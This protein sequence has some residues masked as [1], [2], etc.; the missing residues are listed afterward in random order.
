METIISAKNLVKVYGEPPSETIAL[1]GVSLKIKKGEFAAIIG[2][3][4]SGK[5]TLMHILGCLDRA[6]SGEY[7]FENKNVSK[8]SENKLAQIR[9]KKIGFVF[10]FFNLLPRTSTTKNVELP[11][12]YSQVEK[13]QRQ[14]KA[15]ELLSALGLSDKLNSTPAQLSGGQQQK[16]AIARALVNNPLLIFAD[17]PTGNLDT[18]SSHE[19]MAIF[20]KLNTE[21]HTIIIITHEK[22]IAGY[23][24][25]TITIHDGRIVSDKKNPSSKNKINKLKSKYQKSVKPKV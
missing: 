7:Y 15:R 24:S 10:Q 19:I 8:L 13:P 11:L 12:I 18:K 22:D 14:K 23:A 21:G 17:E 9:N 3:S 25:R 4:G 20:K 1:A 2:P 16:V 5:S 6:S